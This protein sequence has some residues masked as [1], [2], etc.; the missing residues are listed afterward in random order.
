MDPIIQKELS[1]ETLTAFHKQLLENCKQ[2]VRASR[3]HMNKWYSQWDEINKTYRAHRDLD[4]ADKK[5]SMRQEPVKMIIPSMYTQVQTF[6][7]FAH[8]LL[9]QR[10][11]FYELIGSN[12][13]NQ[14]GSKLGE[15]LLERDL[16]KNNFRGVVLYQ[17]LQDVGKLGLGVLKHSWVEEKQLSEVTVT[18]PGKTIMGLPI[19]APRTEV[20]KQWITK[21]KG[22]R[23]YNVSPYRFF[24]DVRLPLFRFQ[25]G[26]FC[27]SEDDYSYTTLKQMEK[28]GAVAG[29]KFIKPL[30]V[31]TNED[32]RI[33]NTDVARNQDVKLWTNET[34]GV[35]L[36]TEVQIRLVP[37]EYLIAGKP[38]GEEDYPVL[39]VIWYAN[40]QRVIKCEPMNY[41]HN[42]FTYDIGLYSP[43]LYRFLSDGIGGMIG[44]LQD[45]QNWLINTR[46]T[47]VRK[48]I[49]ARYVVDPMGIDIKDV[50]ERKPII[51]LKPGVSRSGVDKWIKQLEVTDV[52][53]SH[54]ADAQVMQGFIEST[55][56]I[57]QN[58]LGQ[59]NTGRRS[60][61]EAQ[62]VMQSSTGRV[63]TPISLIWFLGLK[64]LGEKLLSNLQQGLDEETYV[65]VRGMD[66]VDPQTGQISTEYEQFKPVDKEKIIGQYEFRMYDGTL[67]SEKGYTAQVLQDTLTQELSNPVAAQVFGMNPK[68]LHDEIL[69][70]QGVKGLQRF[71][72]PPQMQLMLQQ[73]AA[74]HLIQGAPNQGKQPNVSIDP[75]PSKS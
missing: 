35:V 62:N 21:Y 48:N 61:A 46:I 26:E 19:S 32:R 57:N 45:T 51:R 16:D 31:Q 64:S 55:T 42:A 74:Q 4:I 67:A 39:Y 30:N 58:M 53:Q 73:V 14:D 10:E 9:T 5:A 33:G 72:L 52:T 40:D 41:D 13:G 12:S 23:I 69:R 68:A 22:N 18:I 17:F 11:Y 70:L 43:D 6:V 49:E 44:D 56:G 75:P 29:T 36:L 38:M 15:A 47:S 50:D 60:A 28:D 8:K 27:A 65:L 37:S 2:L 54:F 34:R 71:Q 7:S 24:P 66:S 25:E 1:Q 63:G 20:Q 3:N 59:F